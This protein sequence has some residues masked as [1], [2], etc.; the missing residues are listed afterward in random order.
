M[1][2]NEEVKTE[3]IKDYMRSRVVAKT[4]L[5]GLFNK[6]SAFENKY[7]KDCS[8]FSE[9]EV[10]SMYRAFNAK[11]VNVLLN[12]NV[13]L[14]NYTAYRIYYKQIH[15]ENTYKL[16]NKDMMLGCID[17]NIRAQQFLTREQM[18]DVEDQLLNFTDKAIV[19]CLWHGIAGK[20]MDDIVSIN[21]DMVSDEDM[22]IMLHSGKVVPITQ[23]LY[24]Y[25]CE[26]FR[27]TEYLCYGPTMR[28]KEMRGYGR[29]YKERDNAKCVNSKDKQFRWVYR[30]IQVFRDYVDLP[31]LT[32]KNIQASGLL[33]NIRTGMEET[34]LDARGFLQTD[35]GKSIAVQYG[36]GLDYYVD[37]I[38]GKFCD[39]IK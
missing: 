11:S 31:M 24:D 34:G 18:N 21:E 3:F 4:T 1:F 7:N 5:T 29:L 19:E 25:L 37:T 15:H 23:R 17:E 36:Y 9:T 27:E 35:R 6:V 12:N 38:A 26:A 8:D 14:E 16:I 32:M 30:K 20:D 10:L 2:F 28:V 33:H 13:Y 22:T 39:I